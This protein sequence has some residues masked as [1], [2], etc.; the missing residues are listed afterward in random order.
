V[1]AVERT[2]GAQFK[3]GNH[4]VIFGQASKSIQSTQ[5]ISAAM[6]LHGDFRRQRSALSVESPMRGGVRPLGALCSNSDDTDPILIRGKVCEF[7]AHGRKRSWRIVYSTRLHLI[8]ACRHAL[9]SAPL[10]AFAPH[11]RQPMRRPQCLERCPIVRR[12][13][14]VGRNA[15]QHTQPAA[16]CLKPVVRTVLGS[17]A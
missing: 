14:P 12:S 7:G 1:V 2:A 17:S 15:E 9:C 6:N 8:D 4:G 13:S 3:C 10:L 5:M 16:S 11:H